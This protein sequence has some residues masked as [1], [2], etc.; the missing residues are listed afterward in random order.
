MSL[1]INVGEVWRVLLADGWHDVA[2][3]ADS[4]QVSS[5]K[6]D[7]YEYVDGDLSGGQERA[8]GVSVLGFSFSEDGGGQL[9]GPLTSILA[10]D[11]KPRPKP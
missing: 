8:A 3:S 9:Y 1:A 4:N 2:P 5:F 10:V 6:L 11:T 7:A